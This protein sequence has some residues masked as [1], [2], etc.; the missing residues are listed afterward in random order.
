VK[1]Y[2]YSTKKIQAG[3]LE[4]ENHDVCKVLMNDL[5]TRMKVVTVV[6]TVI[7]K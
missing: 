3:V 7:M 6:V 4:V 1:D 2:L 5:V